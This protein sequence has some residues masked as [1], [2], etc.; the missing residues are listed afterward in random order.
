LLRASGGAAATLPGHLY[1]KGDYD[2][3]PDAG[4]EA[5]QA[6]QQILLQPAGGMK[7]PRQGWRHNRE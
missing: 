4:E 6:V 7:K 1:K 2:T 3:D 5:A